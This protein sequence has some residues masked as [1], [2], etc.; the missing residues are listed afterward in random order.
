MKIVTISGKAQHGKD[1]TAQFLTNYL[2]AAGQRV[3]VVHYAD[4]LKFICKQYFNWDGKKDDSGRTLLQRVGT[5]IIRASEPDFWVDSVARFLSHFENEWDF[6]LIPD[7]RF[8]NEIEYWK[9]HNINSTHIRVRRYNFESPL[10][11]EQQNHIS[12]T[13]LDNY[14]SDLV[15]ANT[16]DLEY[17]E[18][19]CEIAASV[20]MKQ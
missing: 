2:T 18:S 5:D 16:Q 11:M 7:C 10:T 15:I 4:Y 14:P 20:L 8:P 17:L 19:L 6:V 3:L 12:E 9:K 13:A 1:T